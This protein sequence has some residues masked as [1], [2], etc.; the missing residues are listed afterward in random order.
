AL[1]ALSSVIF[2]VGVLGLGTVISSS[3][4]SQ[5]LATQASIFA[6]FLP[7]MI[8]SGFMFTLSNMPVLLQLISRVVP[9]RY[10]IAVSRGL[11]LKG[12]G[13]SVL[14][15]SLLGLT[16]YAMF[17]VGLSIKKFRKELA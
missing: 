3:M 17:T 9:A 1:F 14:W 10:F 2:L 7:A 5:L 11:F 16:L 13:I 15:P 4:K 12:V 8:F 6:T